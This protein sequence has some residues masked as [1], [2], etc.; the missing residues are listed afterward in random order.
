[1]RWNFCRAGKRW[2]P[3]PC[4]VDILEIAPFSLC[5]L[6]R[7]LTILPVVEIVLAVRRQLEVGP[8]LGLKSPKC[9]A[10]VLGDRILPHHLR[11]R[12]PKTGFMPLPHGLPG[13]GS[14]AMQAI[15][16]DDRR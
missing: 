12:R 3:S 6:P 10:L 8:G 1:M 2:K 14:E 4:S 5:L 15:P 16:E 11:R 13:L 9:D 7:K